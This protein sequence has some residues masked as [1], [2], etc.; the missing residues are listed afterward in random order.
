[1][2]FKPFDAHFAETIENVEIHSTL[3]R[4]L[5]NTTSAIMALEFYSKWEAH[6]SKVHARLDQVQNQ[7]RSQGKR[8]DNDKTLM[9]V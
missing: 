6:M 9:S 3:F 1:M 5:A 4:D 8:N 2:A 7:Q